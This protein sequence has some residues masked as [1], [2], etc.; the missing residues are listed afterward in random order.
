MH[1]PLFETICIAQHQIQNIAYHQ[2]RYENALR[3]FYGKSAVKIYDFLAIIQQSADFPTELLSPVTRCRIAYNATDYQI[4]FF[5]YQ[6]KLIQTFKPIV[7]DDIDYNFKISDR[8]LLNTL[9]AQRGDCDEIMIIKQGKVTD[10]SI[11]NLCFRRGER[12][13]TP[14]SPLL[15]G[16]QRQALLEKGIIQEVPIFADDIEDFDE[17]RL[18]NAMNGLA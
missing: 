3:H 10:C 16:T 17:I 4:Q 1:F 9:F 14:D 7:C 5:P 6:P 13:F 12:W 15:A 8:T 18:I 11:G 2:Q